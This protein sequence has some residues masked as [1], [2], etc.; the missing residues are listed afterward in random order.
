[1]AGLGEPCSPVG[2]AGPRGP[3]GPGGPRGPGSPLLGPAGP[4]DPGFPL[5]PWLHPAVAAI[6]AA[7]STSPAVRISANSCLRSGSATVAWLIARNRNGKELKEFHNKLEHAEE[8][9]WLKNQQTAAELLV[10]WS[11]TI[12]RNKIKADPALRSIPIIAVTSHALVMPQRGG[13]EGREM[14]CDDYDPERFSAR[15]LHT[16]RKVGV[17]C[18]A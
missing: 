16:C 3:W 11:S 6:N 13:K 9:V 4:G 14:G 10:C 18:I 12:T 5:G 7:K 2:P 8:L 17:C 15:Q 1:M